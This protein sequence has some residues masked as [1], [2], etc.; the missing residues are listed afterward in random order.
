M[1]YDTRTGVRKSYNNNGIGSLIRKLVAKNKM[2][3]PC[4]PGHD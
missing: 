1:E 2:A 4:L 3:V